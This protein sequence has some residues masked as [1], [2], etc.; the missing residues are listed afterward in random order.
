MYTNKVTCVKRLKVLKREG[1]KGTEK[2]TGT[3]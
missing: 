2:K 1:T 3:Y